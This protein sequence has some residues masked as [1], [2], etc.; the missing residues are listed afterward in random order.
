MESNQALIDQV[1]KLTEQMKE[2]KIEVASIRTAQFA[3]LKIDGGIDDGMMQTVPINT[4]L[5]SLLEELNLKP[6]FKKEIVLE[7]RDQKEKD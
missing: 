1:E 7:D 2:L 4:L 3:N 6:F 5:K